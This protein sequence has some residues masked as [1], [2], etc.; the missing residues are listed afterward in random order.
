MFTPFRARLC[1]YSLL[2]LLLVLCGGASSASSSSSSFGE[3]CTA[4][5]GSSSP[6]SLSAAALSADALAL[7]GNEYFKRGEYAKAL[8]CYRKAL[9]KNPNHEAAAANVGLVAAARGDGDSAIQACEPIV[10]RGSQYAPAHYCLGL[11]WL[12]KQKP[13]QAV[14]HLQKARALDANLN[15]MGALAEAGRQASAFALDAGDAAAAEQYAAAALDEG[16]PPNDD[17]TRNRWMGDTLKFRAHALRRLGRHSEAAD[18]FKDAAAAQPRD[19]EALAN[20]GLARLHLGETDRAVSR[21]K[22]SLKLRPTFHN[23]RCALARAYHHGRKEPMQAVGEFR[24]VLRSDANHTDAFVGLLAAAAEACDWSTREL[25]ERRAI[26]WLHK[27]LESSSASS[28]VPITPFDALVTTPAPPHMHR[29]LA[30]R[31]ARA[32]AEEARALNEK[33]ATGGQRRRLSR[34]S[35]L[36]VAYIT[37]DLGSHPVGRLVAGLFARHSAL[38][39]PTIFSLRAADGSRWHAEAVAG[40]QLAKGR[41]VELDKADHAAVIKSILEFKPH[42]LVDLMG[43]TA[44]SNALTR[45]MVAASRLA[46]VGIGAVGYPG[47]L[48]D[49]RNMPY[50]LLDARVAPPSLVHRGFAERAIYL[51]HTYQVNSHLVSPAPPLAS[52]ATRSSEGLPEDAFVFAHFNTL[53]KLSPESFDLWAAILARVPNSVL[54]LLRMPAAAEAQLRVEATSRGLAPGRIVFGAFRSG[55]AHVARCELADL[56]LDN[57]RYGAHTTAT[58]ALWSGVPVLTLREEQMP[59]RVAGS[60]IE[61]L[62]E[63]DDVEPCDL[64]KALIATSVREFEDMAVMLATG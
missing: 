48:G 54:W 32:A 11:G 56:F 33:A 5:P 21:L 40:V 2:V 45:E 28:R 36:R 20:E 62:C 12:T 1:A 30:M 46:P 58:D 31:Y 37:S 14:V 59:S 61:A 52:P 7:W 6:S 26:R 38:V 63:D 53:R 34:G 35:P 3:Q 50:A 24:R 27:T 41:V 39:V 23:A 51:P 13:V 22:K 17:A 44:A 15:L 42:V 49:E 4:P 57:T 9:L 16:A 25:D 43:F 18:V 55:D 60:L 64:A 47:T 10:K 29:A 8:P 19:V